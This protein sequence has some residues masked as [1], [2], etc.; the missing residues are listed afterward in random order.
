MRIGLIGYGKMGKEIASLTD[1][2][3]M[4][5]SQEI[6]PDQRGDVDVYIDFS[7]GSAVLGNLE[8]VVAA[9]KPIVIGT[10][11]W[12]V[13]AGRRMVE[14]GGIGAIYS[15]NF[16]IGVFHFQRMVAEARRQLEGYEAGGYELHHSAKRD[17]PS[18]TG[19]V[20]GQVLGSSVA[21]VRCGKIPGTHVAL[22]DG[23]DDT[24][25]LIH[26]ARSRQGFARG[27]LRAAEW[28][29]G[30]RGFFTMEDLCQS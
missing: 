30:K 9:G 20:L 24:I 17:A 29:I 25:E 4:R 7:V 16:S 1:Q 5:T 10:T 18:G 27:A 13:E 26:R 11:D 3:V 22:F 8:T 23:D 28:I 6:Q 15:P 19:Q 2:V 21:S 14:E 12:N